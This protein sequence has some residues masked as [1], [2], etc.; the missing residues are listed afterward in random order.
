MENQ[1]LTTIP[2]DTFAKEKLQI[3]AIS[4]DF[5]SSESRSSEEESD[6]NSEEEKKIY[7][8]ESN[9]SDYLSDEEK[10]P[11]PDHEDK[12]A[13]IMVSLKERN[14]FKRREA[15]AQVSEVK[16]F[17]NVARFIRNL[18][19]AYSKAKYRNF[20][21]KEMKDTEITYIEQ[22]LR[23]IGIK[24][25]FV[26][27]IGEHSDKKDKDFSSKLKISKQDVEDLF[28]NVKELLSYH[29]KILDKLTR[30]TPKNDTLADIFW[31]IQDCRESYLEYCGNHSTAYSKLTK[32]F[33]KGNKKFA[34]F[35]AKLCKDFHCVSF[36]SFMISPV[37]RIPRYLLYIKDLLKHTFTG[38]R[39]FLI[40]TECLNN[41]KK[42][43]DGINQ[44]MKEYERYIRPTP[45]LDKLPEELKLSERNCVA[46]YD[47]HLISGELQPNNKTKFKVLLFTDLLLVL[48]K[49]HYGYKYWSSMEINSACRILHLTH[50]KYYSGTIKVTSKDKC[51]ILRPDAKGQEVTKSK[52]FVQDLSDCI[53]ESFTVDDASGLIN[54]TRGPEDY[55]IKCDVIDV[56][57][58]G[59]SCVY[60]I[61]VKGPCSSFCHIIYKTFSEIMKIYEKLAA[62]EELKQSLPVFP[63]KKFFLSGST[64]K[65]E[66]RRL[67]LDYFLQNLFL[68]PQFKDCQLAS[69]FRI[70]SGT[71]TEPK[72]FSIDRIKQK[73]DI[74]LLNKQT[75][76]VEVGKSTEALEV[77]TSL[78]DQL[79]INYVKDKRLFLFQN[80]RMVK[81]FED[82]ESILGVLGRFKSTNKIAK[83]SVTKIKKESS[84]NSALGKYL[85]LPEDSLRIVFM[86]WNY[87]PYDF[88]FKED[89]SVDCLNFRAI[90]IIAE[91][92]TR[93]CSMPSRLKCQFIGMWCS[94]N[95]QEALKICGIDSENMD[96]TEIK[97]KILDNTSVCSISKLLG[98]DLEDATQQDIK[99][100]NEVW[101][102]AKYTMHSKQRFM[103][104]IRL[105][106]KLPL[107]GKA[108]FWGEVYKLKKAK[109]PNIQKHIWIS[110][111]I[112]TLSLVTSKEKDVI[113]SYKLD[114]VELAY[115]PNA[116]VIN[117]S[118]TNLRITV[119]NSFSIEKLVKEY[120]ENLG[121]KVY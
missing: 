35:C 17:R 37:Q 120:Q 111:G 100:I 71:R 107:Y 39:M 93:R 95:H 2:R 84:E 104:L 19:E 115:Y 83:L 50:M 56:E 90:Q 113:I 80:C 54:Y 3:Q 81:V 61:R 82:T 9:E 87:L 36:D 33:L 32:E 98:K 96:K 86:K 22:L 68:I 4:F 74:T 65:I 53:L 114:S 117:P 20:I 11:E 109:V 41:V 99:L 91:F 46:E 43:L 76:Q 106:T 47:M 66:Y 60:A 27:E 112:D 97:A 8:S 105:S 15:N 75:M 7:D 52:E 102:N 89:E 49:K 77:C 38:S 10:Q 118:T 28:P 23:M 16:T 58:Q 42:L 40:Y 70:N 101:V 116:L 30:W 92:Q 67:A 18:K 51:L 64:M 110:V 1:T 45:K 59:K 5:L 14:N 57:W 69:V 103:E 24:E 85:N 48:K 73:L 79:K 25:A 62:Q 21:V 63:K 13:E 31:S 55:Y 44:G 119:E 88:T 121:M 29:Y 94:L 108:L 26:K 12:S 72:M 34:K 78:C 6:S